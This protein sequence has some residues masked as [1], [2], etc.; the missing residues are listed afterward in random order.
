MK[1]YLIFPP[2]LLLLL[3]I[4]ALSL[5]SDAQPGYFKPPVIEIDFGDDSNPKDMELLSVRKFY[6]RRRDMCPDD[7]NFSF[8]S[9]TSDCFGGNWITVP[10]DHTPG[11]VR[12]RMMLVNAAYEPAPFFALK[13]TGLK[14]NTTY[15]L[16]AWFVNVC[17]RGVGCVPTPPVISV[18]VSY[19]GKKITNFTAGPFAPT[20]SDDWKRCAGMFTTPEGANNVFVVM[21]DLA[22]GGC[23]NDFA[24][25]DL[26]VREYVIKKEEPP[27]PKVEAP[28]VVTKPTEE[29]PKPVV[30]AP[31]PV[32]LK[33]TT[34]DINKEVIDKKPVATKPLIKAQKNNIPV[35]D[36]LKTR[37]NA[38]AKKIEAPESEIEIKLYDNG[39]IDGD[40]VTIYHNNALVVSHA[41][42]SVKPVT[43]KIKLDENNPHH[44]L[45]MVADNLGSIPPNTSL[46]VVTAK[47]KRYEVFISSSE[48]KNAKVVIDLKKEE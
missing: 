31:E 40:T 12:G 33:K 37:D 27:A 28:P 29:K 47:D 16:S 5:T 30:K 38:L 34:S 17:L 6:N 15:E 41:G 43:L 4:A 25:D 20:G 19:E 46:M 48:Q 18:H 24:M 11:S 13:L 21:S 10:K 2:V 44:E 9:Y 8:V 3:F 36:I 42:L 26:Q 22:N 39:E 1:R 14:G 35:P 7:G 32:L 45:V 23:G